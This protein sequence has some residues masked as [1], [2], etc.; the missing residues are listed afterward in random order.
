MASNGKNECVGKSTNLDSNEHLKSLGQSELVEIVKKLKRKNGQLSDQISQMKVLV[1]KME[2]DSEITEELSKPP[3]KKSKKE[4]V[5]E[6]KRKIAIRFSY[7]GQ[8]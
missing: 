6:T 1:S 3:K 7:D 4:K 2:N 5:F 8:G